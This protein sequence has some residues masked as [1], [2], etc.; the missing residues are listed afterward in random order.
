MS[1]IGKPAAVGNGL[2][3]RITGHQLFAADVKIGQFQRAEARSVGNK[4]IVQRK[5]LDMSGRVST[6][7]DPAADM[8]FRHQ[9]LSKKPIKQR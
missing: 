1:T 5:E 3:L 6:T 9:F 7:A 8:A 4:T 2:D